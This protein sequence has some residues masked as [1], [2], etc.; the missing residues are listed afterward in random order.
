MENLRPDCV[1]SW[2]DLVGIFVRNFQGTY[3]RLDNPW[4]LKNCR[5]T[6]GVSRGNVMSCLILL[7]QMPLAP[8]VMEDYLGVKWKEESGKRSVDNVRKIMDYGGDK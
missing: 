4:D 5:Q 7:T 1:Q 3:V 8:I 2:A 6:L